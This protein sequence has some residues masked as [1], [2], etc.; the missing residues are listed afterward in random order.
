MNCESGEG[1]GKMK[2]L[3]IKSLN[4]CFE[5]LK[6]VSNFNET[7]EEGTIHGIIGP[8]GAGKTTLF[9]IITGLYIPTEGEI[10]FKGINLVGK[11]AH[12]IARLGIARTFQNLRLFNDLSVIDN[13]R[14]G[15]SKQ[16]ELKSLN[17]LFVRRLRKERYY[18]C[19][20]KV[21]YLLELV[22]LTKRAEETAGGLPYGLQRKLE[23]ARALATKPKLLLLD[24]PAAGM[25]PQEVKELI[26][27]IRVIK[28]QFDLTVVLIEHQM[29]VIVELCDVVTVMNFGRI[30]ARG[31]VWDIQNNPEVIKA[32]LGEE[33]AVNE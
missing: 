13:I 18:A 16:R 21:K 33:E 9:N 23:I 14:V 3:E 5:G 30:I 8:N 6:A 7:I 31:S 15:Q 1:M 29:Q 27:L 32:Y 12:Q 26:T 25:N 24:E 17:N 22:G 20:N 28:C 2:L 4:H 11:K 19:E 10:L